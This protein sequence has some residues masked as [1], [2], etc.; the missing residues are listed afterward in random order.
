MNLINT[1]RSLRSTRKY[2]KKQV[3]FETI[4][5]I[6]DIARFTHSSDNIQNWKFI[7]IKDSETKKHIIQECPDQDW[8]LTA[9]VLIAVCCEKNEA[10][11]NYGA[12]GDLIATQNCSI[13][14]NN[15]MLIA[16][17]LGLGTCWVGKFNQ[18]I[19]AQLLNIPSDVELQAILTLGYPEA[20]KFEFKTPKR[21]EVTKM[22]YLEKYGS[23]DINT[24]LWPLIKYK[25]KI[26]K[27]L[28]TKK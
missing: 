3:Q 28:K 25:D 17:D 9:P 6:L 2:S 7:I 22:L 26:K 12:M 18:S 20:T 13:I 10:K 11:K 19:I 4:A 23:T 16:N 8:M 15:I 1:I 5:D 14:T 21:L 24:S 27:F